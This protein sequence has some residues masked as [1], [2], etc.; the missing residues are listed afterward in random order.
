M[1]ETHSWL[2]DHLHP[3]DGGHQKAQ[4]LQK[5]INISLLLSDMDDS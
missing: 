1:Q 3:N 5:N 4:S 2:N